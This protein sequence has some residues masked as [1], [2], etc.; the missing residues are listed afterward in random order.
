MAIRYSVVLRTEVAFPVIPGSLASYP[1]LSG[2]PALLRT[3][4]GIRV[5]CKVKCR[6]CGLACLSRCMGYLSIEALLRRSEVEDLPWIVIDPVFDG[7][8]G[9]LIDGLDFSSFGHEST[10]N[11]VRIFISSALPGRVWMSVE[12][13]CARLV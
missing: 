12:Q 1:K 10:N 5:G 13:T 3:H 8:D 11:A 7:A 4:P 2:S 6:I 9:L